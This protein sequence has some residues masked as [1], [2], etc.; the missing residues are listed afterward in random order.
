MSNYRTFFVSTMI[1]S[2]GTVF[3]ALAILLMPGALNAQTT[4][5][6]SCF[7]GAS[8]SSKLPPNCGDGSCD[9]GC[10]CIKPLEKGACGCASG[11]PG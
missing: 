6:R 1:G 7:T 2:I 4:S 9:T 3:V 8:C 10:M 11:V 5:N